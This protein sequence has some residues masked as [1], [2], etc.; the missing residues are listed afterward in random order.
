MSVSAA[1]G[2]A[3][4]VDPA[5]DPEQQYREAER[6]VSNRLSPSEKSL[7]DGTIMNVQGDVKFK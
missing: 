1:A 5:V 4:V 7:F 6:F 2:T 3:I